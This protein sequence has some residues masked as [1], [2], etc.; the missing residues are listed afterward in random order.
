[1]EQ[2]EIVST[3]IE[4]L[5]ITYSKEVRRF[6]INGR[7]YTPKTLAE[8]FNDLIY[9]K[10][11]DNIPLITNYLSRKVEI[12]DEVLR[13]VSSPPKKV[14]ETD[15]E[16]VRIIRSI[17][18]QELSDSK[19][20]KIKFLDPTTNTV[21][22]IHPK[23]YMAKTDM[24]E[25]DFYKYALARHFTFDVKSTDRLVKIKKNIGSEMKEFEALNLY[26]APLWQLSKPSSENMSNRLQEF[27]THLFPNDIDREYVFDWLHYLVTSRN[28][29]ILCLVGGKGTGK[30]IFSYMCASL[31]GNEYAVEEANSFLTGNFNGSM[32]NARLIALDEVN[33]EGNTAIV[34]CRKLTNDR[35]SMELKGVD[36]KTT[37]NHV[38]FII[39]S[40]EITKFAI[41]GTE[42][43]FSIPEVTDVQL[44]KNKQSKRPGLW[45]RNDIA[46]FD[47][48]VKNA[49]CEEFINFAW[50]CYNRKP[51]NDNQIGC[52]REYYFKVYEKSL[53]LAAM[54]FINV[55]FEMCIAP[56]VT[57]NKHFKFVSEIIEEVNQR[58]NNKGYRK[59]TA[60]QNFIE[61]DRVFLNGAIVERFVYLSSDK[62]NND[63]VGYTEEYFN[64]LMSA[65]KYEQVNKESGHE[66]ADNIL[67]MAEKGED[68]EGSL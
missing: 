36:T 43:R 18:Y 54:S 4:K 63:K 64:Y 3:I 51:K 13:T 38:S 47:K 37:L 35:V 12:L 60:V 59:K 23:T 31:V 1:M 25:T 2:K 28:Q 6:A 46:S 8:T 62:G 10:F 33:L 61:K 49:N 41:D 65:N 58:E 11:S 55:M 7:T 29:T 44:Y 20:L 27:F 16:D 48:M 57:Y 24:K 21:I 66:I 30:T 26:N 42:R 17:P 56:N 15:A 50:W 67:D 39:T 68:E 40:N 5:G 32:E 52:M 14:Y 9:T 34:K 53:P 19:A 45:G 22:D